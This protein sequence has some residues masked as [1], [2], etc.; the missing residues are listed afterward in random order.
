MKKLDPNL[1]YLLEGDK[2]LPETEGGIPVMIQF[3]A[4]P[5]ESELMRLKGLGIEIR[6]ITGSIASALV[7]KESLAD[8]S[9]VKSVRY[10]EGPGRLSQE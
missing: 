4:P 10:I 3:A 1:L 7:P 6:S 5:K 8:L 2:D 9:A